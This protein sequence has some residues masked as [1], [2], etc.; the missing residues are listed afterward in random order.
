MLS[1]SGDF[2]QSHGQA[3]AWAHNRVGR[4][5]TVAGVAS[6]GICGELVAS[7]LPGQLTETE[8]A[9]GKISSQG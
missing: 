5:R 4:V 8:L 3:C 6:C 9:R 2:S 7:L 1:R